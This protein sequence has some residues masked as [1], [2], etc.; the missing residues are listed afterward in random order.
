[1]ADGQN[2]M[3]S[4]VE[5]GSPELVRQVTSAIAHSMAECLIENGIDLADRDQVIQAL[6][7]YNYGPKSINACAPLAANMAKQ[8]GWETNL[9]GATTATSV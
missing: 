6:R 5:Q 9:P 4:I 1:M 8:R 7:R 2:I 3:Q